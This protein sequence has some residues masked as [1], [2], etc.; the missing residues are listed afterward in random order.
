[1]A[2]LPAPI[3]GESKYSPAY[4]RTA[5]HMCRLAA[6]D[7]ELADGIGVSISTIQRWRATHPAF[8][9]ACEIGKDAFD[10]R[11]EHALAM[12]AVGYTFDAIELKVV[13]AGGGTSEVV[14][15]KVRKHVPPDVTAQIFWLKNRKRNEW[16]DRPAVPEEEM[17]GT[18]STSQIRQEF[19]RRILSVAVRLEEIRGKDPERFA[20]IVE[21]ESGR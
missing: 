9:K 3:I 11:V 4:C 15:E 10:A 21:G 13:S 12:R 8:A 18:R 19:T 6:T 16:C 7:M 17:D 1:M 20:K 14:H 2:T 5:E